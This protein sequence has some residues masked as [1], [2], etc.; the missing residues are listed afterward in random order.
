MRCDLTFCSLLMMLG[1]GRIEA[2]KYFRASAQRWQTKQEQRAGLTCPWQVDEC[3]GVLTFKQGSGYPPRSG[4][5]PQWLGPGQPPARPQTPSCCTARRPGELSNP[6]AGDASAGREVTPRAVQY[7]Q[8]MYLVLGAAGGHPTLCTLCRAEEGLGVHDRSQTAFPDVCLYSVTAKLVRRGT[9]AKDAGSPVSLPHHHH[10]RPRH[11]APWVPPPATTLGPSTSDNRR[12][13]CGRIEDA[14]S[15]RLALTQP[16]A[17]SGSARVFV[18]PINEAL[19]DLPVPLRPLSWSLRIPAVLLSLSVSCEPLGCGLPSAPRSVPARLGGSLRG[20]RGP[21][22]RHPRLGSALRAVRRGTAAC[23]CWETPRGLSQG[24]PHGVRAGRLQT[25]ACRPE[26]SS[27]L[28]LGHAPTVST[29]RHPL[30]RPPVSRL[31]GVPEALGAPG[32]AGR[33]LI[34]SSRT[35][36]SGF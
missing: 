16:T 20:W 11:P 15:P 29:L 3:S 5:A 6:G 2:S 32:A 28:R 13:L 33:S 31:E 17:P 26:G 30:F 25:G 23:R 9:P 4:P 27:H 8:C 19:L 7:G 24:L 21:A 1:E 34:T 35:S 36:A 18:D 10:S 14:G 22:R 12:L